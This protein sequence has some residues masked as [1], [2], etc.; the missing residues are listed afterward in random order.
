MITED[1]TTEAIIFNGMVLETLRDF[2]TYRSFLGIRF[3][4][5]RVIHRFSFKSAVLETTPI[6]LHKI[7]RNEED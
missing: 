7:R 5:K 3:P 1:K 6:G 4:S 2:K